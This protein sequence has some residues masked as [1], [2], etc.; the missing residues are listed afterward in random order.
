MARRRVAQDGG[1]GRFWTH[2]F[3]WT[4]WIYI[5]NHIWN[6]HVELY[7][8]QPHLKKAWKLAVQLF[9]QQMVTEHT[10]TGSRGRDAVSLKTPSLMWQ[11]MIKRD[12]KN[13]FSFRSDG[14]VAH[15][16]HPNAWPTEER[17]VPRISGFENHWGLHP[18]D[19]KCNKGT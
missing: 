9:L 14:F 10:E 6:V 19:S 15:S 4:H 12:F 18:G 1:K 8:E 7:I 11:P 17:W 16:R 13:R 3:P 2:L 5:R